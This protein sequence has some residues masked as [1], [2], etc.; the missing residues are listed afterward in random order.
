MTGI[1]ILPAGTE[2]FN[3]EPRTDPRITRVI[4]FEALH[5][6]FR[7][8]LQVPCY[9]N[10]KLTS[11]DWDFSER[12]IRERAEELVRHSVLAGTFFAPGG[13]WQVA[14][15]VNQFARTVVYNQFMKYQ[16]R[17]GNHE[18]HEVPECLQ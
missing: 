17:S 16:V 13:S 1:A 4:A 9:V 7:C 15:H 3:S 14:Q 5:Q 10:D 11:E 6:K 8:E 2:P 18:G 12:L